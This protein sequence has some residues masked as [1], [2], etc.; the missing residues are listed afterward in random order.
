M[1]GPG[2]R[3][4]K[5]SD[6]SGPHA[7]ASSGGLFKHPEVL[8]IPVCSNT[9]CRA[10]VLCWAGQMHLT[11]TGPRTEP[12]MSQSRMMKLCQTNSSFLSKG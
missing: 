5:R 12:G 7:L 2:T 11:A 4:F 1:S 6:V 9:V 10:S 3:V 8:E